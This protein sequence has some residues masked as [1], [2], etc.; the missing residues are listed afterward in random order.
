MYFAV[1]P[2]ETTRITALCF[3]FPV[4]RVQCLKECYVKALGR[5]IGFGVDRITCHPCSLWSPDGVTMGTR[6]TVDEEPLNGWTVE[7]SFLD[8]KVRGGLRRGGGM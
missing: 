3:L 4:C 8:S 7:E 6:L 2:Q 5:G 1:A